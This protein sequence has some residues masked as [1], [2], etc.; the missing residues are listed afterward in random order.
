MK[1]M[2]KK[3]LAAAIALLG[4]SAASAVTGTYAWFVAANTVSVSEM[5]IKAE[6]EEG[7][8]ISAEAETKVWKTSVNATHTTAGDVGFI[9]TSTADGSSWFHAN[10]EE[11]D[12]H[13]SDGIT[14]SNITAGITAPIL[15][16]GNGIGVWN[17]GTTD[18]TTDDKNVYLLNHFYIKGSGNE[19]TNQELILKT[20]TCTGASVSTDLNK[21]LRIAFVYNN[22][23][24]IFAPITTTSTTYIVGGTSGTSVTLK[25]VNDVV[26]GVGETGVTIPDVNTTSP[27]DL[28]VYLYF[29]G[30]DANCKTSNIKATLD[31]LNISFSLENRANT[32]A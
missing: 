8:L 10:S 16:T 19:L 31:R 20:L 13:H 27:L 2:K 14:V 12:N 15:N 3:L 26:I 21:S 24:S 17:H 6:A 22:T 30:E 9:P 18:V 11:A 28:S 1:K 7:I 29:E 5:S 32:N 25:A 23:A 4:F